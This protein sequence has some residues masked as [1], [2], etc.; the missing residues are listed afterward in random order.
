[1]YFYFEQVV[2]VTYAD[3]HKTKKNE[4]VIVTKI[5]NDD[6]KLIL[7][8]IITEINREKISN[9]KSFKS[10]VDKIQ[11]TGRSSL[12]L[13]IIRDQE[14]LWITIKFKDN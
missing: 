14:S 4:G 11:K 12:L 13:K 2:D 1:M 9:P 6:S 7:E 3:A 8:D 10:L 5:Y